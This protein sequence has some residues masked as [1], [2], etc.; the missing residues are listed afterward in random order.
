MYLFALSEM[1][2]NL[3][4]GIGETS[5]TLLFLD[6]VNIFFQFGKTF[7]ANDDILQFSSLPFLTLHCWYFKIPALHC[8]IS[9]PFSLIGSYSIYSNFPSK[10]FRIDNTT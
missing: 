1:S 3:V 2:F 7:F 9:I 10:T 8:V 6:S 5:D 4:N